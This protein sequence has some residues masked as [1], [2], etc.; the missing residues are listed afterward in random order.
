MASIAAA[1]GAVT[2]SVSRKTTVLVLGVQDPSTFAG[3]LMSSKHMAAEALQKQ[4]HPVRIM[5]EAT[6]RTTLMAGRPA[7]N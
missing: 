2:A 4:G 5:N 7:P 6:F 3:K 1:G